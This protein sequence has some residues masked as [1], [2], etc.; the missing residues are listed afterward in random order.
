M[1]I[2]LKV[3][4]AQLETAARQFDAKREECVRL[5]QKIVD[6]AN[7]LQSR[8][9]GEASNAY[10]RK[11]N[12]LAGEIRDIQAIIN[13]HV[14]DLRKAEK[15]YEDADKNVAVAANQLNADVLNY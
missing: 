8:W 7:T 14:N 3:S 15:V 12:E 5:V 4:T 9:K 10:C 2:Q 13:E 11:L 1:A 6:L